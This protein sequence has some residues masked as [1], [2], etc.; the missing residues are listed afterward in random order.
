MSRTI[1][2][3]GGYGTFG[4]RAAERL[5]TD[6]SLEIILAGRSR[7]KADAAVATLQPRLKSRL[8]AMH[9]DALAPDVEA[10][11]ARKP[12]VIYNASGPFQSQEYALARAAIAVGSHYLDLADAR[13]FVA[14]IHALDAD[15]R[16]AGVLVTSGAS[17][18]PALSSAVVDHHLPQF[19]VLESL[20]Y[21]IVPANGFDPG[22]ATT[23]SILTYVGRRFT[24]L[25]DGK[26]TH[27][28]GWQGIRRHTFP[29]IG[30]RW[31][32][33]C[34]IPDLDIFPAR[35]PTLRSIEF[36][37]GLELPLQFFGVWGLS[38]LVRAGVLRRAERLA[39][40]LVKAKSWMNRFGTDA[41]GMFVVMGGRGLDGARKQIAWH[42][43]ARQNHGPYVPQLALTVLTRKLLAG[44]QAERGAM[45]CVGLMTLAEIT[46]DIQ[47]LAITTQS[48]TYQPR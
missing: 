26:S 5:G 17:S 29:D 40:P 31:V 12:T 3:C 32:A 2:I 23:A 19:A 7:T 20:F 44:T 45:P 8:S 41:G 42:L 1:L 22:V 15:A 36:T 13:A 6:P 35:Y 43:I 30:P 4:L 10:L 33:P 38:W 37:A 39:T 11:R 16:A 24:T 46:A 48:T 21:G 25:R 14:G 27:V 18:V 28:H 9:L 47:G 34:D